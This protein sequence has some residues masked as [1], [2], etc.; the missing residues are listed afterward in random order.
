MKVSAAVALAAT[1]ALLTVALPLASRAD[2]A[3]SRA[4]ASPGCTTRQ[5][6]R[7]FASYVPAL[8][9][10]DDNIEDSGGAPDFCAS[11]LVTND[12]STITIGIHAHNRTG[13]VAGGSYTVYLDTDRNTATGGGG[14][15]A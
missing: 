4:P 13:F 6:V 14:V 2:A 7:E 10:Y 12:S 5:S 8:R 15:G 1:G 9:T 11:E 3:S